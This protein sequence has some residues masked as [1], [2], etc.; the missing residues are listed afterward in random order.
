ML[1]CASQSPLFAAARSPRLA[2]SRCFCFSL[3][4][5]LSH[6]Y[7]DS[8]SLYL[9]LSPTAVSAPHYYKPATGKPVYK[10]PTDKIKTNTTRRWRRR[11]QQMQIQLEMLLLQGPRLSAEGATASVSFSAYLLRLR[12]PCR[13]INSKSWA[14]ANGEKARN[15]KAKLPLARWM[16]NTLT[17]HRL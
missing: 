15:S 4:L 14:E 8:A 7:S 16:P 11:R 12:K 10:L 5:S 9:C 17:L 2:A 13:N 6:C 1:L 3:S